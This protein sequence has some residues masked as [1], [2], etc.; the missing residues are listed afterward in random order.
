M[1]EERGKEAEAI[2]CKKVRSTFLLLNCLF[3]FYA[4]I[5]GATFVLVFVQQGAGCGGDEFCG[6]NVSDR[7]L[8]MEIPA[9]AMADQIGYVKTTAL[10]GVLMAATN[11]L[12]FFGNGM[13]AFLAAQICLGFACAF[14]S[15][16][17][18]AWVIDNTSVSESKTVFLKKNK[19]LSIMM[20]LSGLLGGVIADWFLEGI[21]LFALISSVCYIGISLV[22]MPKLEIISTKKEKR[23]VSEP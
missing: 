15:G 23:S 20:I 5:T 14:E 7:S 19:C 8:F 22:M 12:F 9:G 4:G 10:S 21:F 11:V 6:G 1:E 13:M 16:T 18:D 17:L 2:R 3:E